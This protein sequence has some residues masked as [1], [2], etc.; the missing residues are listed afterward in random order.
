[1]KFK[2][3]KQKLKVWNV[4]VFGKIETKLKVAEEEAHAIELITEE[5]TLLGNEQAGKRELRGEI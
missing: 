1:M 2:A 4:E 5:R 3:L